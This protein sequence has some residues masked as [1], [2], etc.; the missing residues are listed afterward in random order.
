MKV[1]KLAI[2]AGLL[3]GVGASTAP[4]RA[5]DCGAVEALLRQGQSVLQIARATGLS[6]GQVEACRRARRKR[7]VISPAGPPPHGA[8]GPAPHG[9]PGPAM[10]FAYV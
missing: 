4:A 5:Q 1:H 3:L 10:A 2:A 9:A 6:S 7:Q 8:P